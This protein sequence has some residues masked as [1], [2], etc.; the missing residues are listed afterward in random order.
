MMTFTLEGVAGQDWLREE[1]SCFAEVRVEGL[2][3]QLPARMVGRG[4]FC[5]VLGL[6]GVGKGVR[7]A[8]GRP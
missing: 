8:G 5:E 7:G 3:F 4:F 6:V 2:H 1:M